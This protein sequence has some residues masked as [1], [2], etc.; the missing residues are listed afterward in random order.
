MIDNKVRRILMIVVGGYLAYLGFGLAKDVWGSG[1]KN[2]VLFL[3]CAVLFLAIGVFAIVMNIKGLIREEEEAE[4]AAEEARREE[5]NR[6]L[7]QEE[8][9]ESETEKGTEEE[10][11]ETGEMKEDEIL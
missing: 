9:F 5:E 1:E 11:A 10:K 3:C 2:T 8:E 6:S 4:E 7:V